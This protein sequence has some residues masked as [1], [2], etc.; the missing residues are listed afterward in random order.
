MPSELWVLWI[1]LKKKLIPTFLHFNVTMIIWISLFPPPA[2]LL[3][4]WE[5]TCPAVHVG[6]CA[7]ML[8][9]WAGHEPLSFIV[10]EAQALFPLFTVGLGRWE[11]MFSCI[12]A[13]VI[14]EDGRVV[15]SYIVEIWRFW[16]I[17]GFQPQSRVKSISLWSGLK[18][19][20]LY[21]LGSNFRSFIVFLKILY[22]EKRFFGIQALKSVFDL[23]L[24]PPPIWGNASCSV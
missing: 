7:V 12:H 17:W 20:P 22:L 23:G 13:W 1:T 24:P 4:F 10:F 15:R 5:W 16:E 21:E 3:K 11:R 18:T 6:H 9:A 8:G 14:Q 19:N 2:Q